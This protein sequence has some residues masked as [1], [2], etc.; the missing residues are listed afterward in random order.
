MFAE[1]SAGMQFFFLLSFDR[2]FSNH[3]TKDN[4]VR[5]DGKIAIVLWKTFDEILIVSGVKQFKNV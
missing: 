3:S 1:Y 5:I 2:F 4:T